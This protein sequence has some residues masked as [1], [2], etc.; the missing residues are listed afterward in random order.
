MKNNVI[1][2]HNN[3]LTVSKVKVYS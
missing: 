2:L 3:Y 1:I